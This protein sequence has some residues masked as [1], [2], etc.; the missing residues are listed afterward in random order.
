MEFNHMATGAQY[1]Q[2]KP[3]LSDEECLGNR[4]KVTYLYHKDAVCG[5]NPT[6]HNVPSIVSALQSN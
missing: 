3:Q 2:S 1:S 5:R 4:K 6:E